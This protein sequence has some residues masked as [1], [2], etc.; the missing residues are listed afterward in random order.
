MPSMVNDRFEDIE[1]LPT[2]YLEGLKEAANKKGK[3]K[4]QWTGEDR[5]T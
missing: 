2:L 4:N 5:D 3:D 1:L